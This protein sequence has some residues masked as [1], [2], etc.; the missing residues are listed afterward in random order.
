MYLLWHW[1]VLVLLTRAGHGARVGLGAVETFL[2]DALHGLFLWRRA[3]GRTLGAV[4]VCGRRFV[5]SRAA[6][7]SEG[8][9][10]RAVKGCEQV[11]MDVGK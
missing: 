7:C 8:R 5:G 6:R 2:A 11:E 3:V 1:C 9:Q 10:E 4:G